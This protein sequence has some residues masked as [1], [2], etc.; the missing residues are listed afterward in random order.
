MAAQ[1]MILGKRKWAKVNGKMY[2]L[3]TCE[4]NGMLV[5]TSIKNGVLVIKKTPEVSG[6]FA[7][8]IK[9]REEAREEAKERAR[10]PLN[11]SYPAFQKKRREILHP[12]GY[13]SIRTPLG[14]F[15]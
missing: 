15:S 2:K 12:T 11:G 8:Y 13:N 5:T 6:K 7:A 14:V 9:K 3:G 10:H 1:L 4:R